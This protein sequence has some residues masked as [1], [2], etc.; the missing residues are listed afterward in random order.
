MRLSGAEEVKPYE[1]GRSKGA[2]VE[3]M[4]DNIAPAYD[5]MN[6]AMTFR[7]H[8]RWLA[9]ALRELGTAAKDSDPKAILDM[10]TGTG[11][12]ALKLAD[13][14]PEA[15]ITGVDLSEGMLAVARGKAAQKGV[16]ARIS[17]SQADCLNLPF[18]EETFDILTIAY[19][20]R[21]FENL[22]KGFS[23]FFRVLRPGGICL[24][25][26]LSR[27]ENRLI[28][29]GYDLYSRTLIPLAGRLISRDR[30]AYSYLP[31]SIAAMP[32]RREITRMLRDEGFADVKFKSL[33][34]GVVTYYL[35]RK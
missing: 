4:F 18:L 10:A 14:Y 13:R 20:V 26:E 11:D 30:R 25:I 27:P 2:Q 5:F 31:E 24:I 34:M 16:Q 1:E 9:K 19:G 3:A 12:V 15:A 35:C 17:F 22:K 7:L 8:R 23:E 28:R 33:T 6:S 21:N 32:P 29:L